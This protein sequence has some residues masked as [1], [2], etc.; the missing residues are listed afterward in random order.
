MENDV[1]IDNIMSAVVAHSKWKTR[2]HTGI[3]MGKIDAPS[4]Q[5]SRDDQCEFGQWLHGEQIDEETKRSKPY[6][7]IKR[8]HA[9]FHGC[10]GKIAHRVEQGE[11]DA[12]KSLLED[13]YREASRKLMLALTL[14]RT[15]LSS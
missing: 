2:L 6:K 14:W 1:I 15:E 7:V 12:A 5:I 3:Q 11:I 10:A 8:L 9:E 4:V 13:D